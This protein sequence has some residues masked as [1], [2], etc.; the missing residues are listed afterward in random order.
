MANTPW[1][2]LQLLKG[3]RKDFDVPIPI[4]V[5]KKKP[6]RFGVV[7]G[8]SFVATSLIACCCIFVVDHLLKARESSMSA[9]IELHQEL[10][11][12]SVSIVQSIRKLSLSNKGLAD[13]I[14]SIQSGS[15]LLTEISR[16]TST[17][18][19]LSNLVVRGD[20]LELSGL[21][22]IER[23]LFDLNAFLLRLSGSS[24][25]LNDR[26][27]LTDVKAKPEGLFFQLQATFSPDLSAN[28]RG[29]L[30]NLNAQGLAERISILR[31]EGLV[32]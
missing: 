15:A 17:D 3:R 9:D 24:F 11:E 23:G 18:L 12:R 1:L 2:R 25:F 10:T 14:A 30:R 20:L 8:S 16:L 21:I 6:L 22:S 28:V 27:L 29:Q 31:N 26:V 19:S 7:I 13:G 4:G 5:P 32:E